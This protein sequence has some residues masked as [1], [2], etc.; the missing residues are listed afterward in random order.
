MTSHLLFEFVGLHRNTGWG[1]MN[2]QPAGSLDDPAALA[3]YPSMISV[4]DQAGAI[5]NLVYRSAATFNNNYNANFFFRAAVSYVTGAHAFK[6]GFNQTAGFLGNTTY[7]YQPFSYRVSAGTANQIT[8]YATPY[9]I[10]DNLDYDFGVFAQD[11]YRPT[12]HDQSRHPLRLLRQQLSGAAP[13]SGP[14][15]P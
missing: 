15:V 2:L 12:R 9:R 8:E 1:N 5:P 4:T 13:R 7:N 14:A 3:A 6:T 10:S 11:R